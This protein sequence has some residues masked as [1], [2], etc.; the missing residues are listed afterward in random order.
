MLT[1]SLQARIERRKWFHRISLPN[2]YRTPGEWDQSELENLVSR[3]RFSELDVLDV[4]TLDGKWAFWA[5]QNGAASVVAIDPEHRYTFD[6]AFMAFDAPDT[7]R[8]I[9]T[10]LEDLSSH[11]GTAQYSAIIDMGVYYHTLDMIGH[12]K[13]LHRH[14]RQGGFALIEGEVMVSEQGSV[15]HWFPDGYLN[16]DK[17]TFW[18]P[19]PLCLSTIVRFCGF[20]TRSEVV[21]L[22]SG[23]QGRMF[24]EAYKE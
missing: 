19:S 15:A 5:Q 4:G 10:T 20:K 9:P 16:G 18:V 14:L 24:L 3:Y 17:T 2:G 1:P 23:V 21:Y 6:L 13:A 7:V 22:Q 11:V 8:M 12:F